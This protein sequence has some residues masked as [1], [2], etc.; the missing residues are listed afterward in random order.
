MWHPYCT[1]EDDVHYH[2][3]YRDHAI[4]QVRYRGI[5]QAERKMGFKV[6]KYTG[7]V[8]SI[9]LGNLHDKWFNYLTERGHLVYTNHPNG[10]TLLKAAF[11]AIRARIFKHHKEPRGHDRMARTHRISKYG[12]WT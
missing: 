11:I 7:K 1:C 2:L 10:R 9:K 12:A 8:K 5:E 4:K 6:I 3:V